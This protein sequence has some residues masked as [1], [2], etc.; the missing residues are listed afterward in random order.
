MVELAST[1]TTKIRMEDIWEKGGY[2]L[3]K[4]FA[5]GVMMNLPEGNP[6]PVTKEMWEEFS[7]DYDWV[8]KNLSNLIKD[9]LGE[10]NGKNRINGYSKAND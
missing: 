4:V 3:H 7:K 2:F 1:K 6:Y 10:L 9:K 5:S 8:L